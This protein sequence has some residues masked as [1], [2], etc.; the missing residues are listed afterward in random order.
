MTNDD[1]TSSIDDQLDRIV[2]EYTDAVEAGRAPKREEYLSQVPRTARPGLER[3]L[4]M[5]DAGVA[6]APSATRPLVAGDHL[7]R[8]KLRREVGR[9]GMAIVWLAEDPELARPVALKILRPGLALDQVHVDRFKREALAIARLKHAHV[10][11]IHE[12]GEAQGYHYLA[13]EYVDGPSLATVLAA[14]PDQRRWTPDELAVAAGIHS[15]AQGQSFEQAICRLLAPVADA[16][17]AAHDLGLVHRDVKPS[18]ILLHRDG[19][20]VVADFGLA[21]GEGDPGLSLT[22]DA[23]GT[24]HYMS[25]EQAQV[26]EATVDHRT[27]IYSLGVTFYEALA[28]RRPFEGRS[29]LEV[30][31]KIKTQVA[32]PLR[33]RNRRVTKNASAVAQ[34]A[35]SRWPEDRYE[36][37]ALLAEDLRA[38]GQGLAT[39]AHSQR[40]GLFSRAAR[41]GRWWMSGQQW[42]YRS[43]R[44]LLGLPLVHIVRGRRMPGQAIRVAKGWIAVGDVALGGIALGGVSAGIFACGGFAF[45]GLLTW[46]G[47]GLGLGVGFGGM[48]ISTVAIAGVAAGWLAFGGVALGYAAIGG[49]PIGTY[50]CGG[51]PKGRYKL[52]G[53]HRDQEAVDFFQESVPMVLQWLGIQ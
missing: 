6:S 44:E 19:R 2:A 11:Q 35:M 25:P 42:E 23:I 5:I 41:N 30:F 27:D 32:P 24:P 45:G 17:Q 51:N 29:I 43:E 14:L 12:V 7:G 20:A 36:S 4:K 28:G 13:M 16:L 46:A 10:V 26:S 31:E 21:K 37:A 22:G 15:L 9:G 47:M 34:R 50:A 3:C 38:L 39:Q 48:M 18:N 52:G 49:L 33:A 53:G 1:T 8:Y 40:L